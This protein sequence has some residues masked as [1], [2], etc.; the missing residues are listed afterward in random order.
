MNSFNAYCKVSISPVRS[1]SKD[2]SEIVTQLLFGELITVHEVNEPWAKITTITDGYEGIIDFKHFQKLTDKE[3]KRWSDGLSILKVRECELDTPWGLLRICRGSFIP[4]DEV[5][6]KIG[7]DHFQLLSPTAANFTTPWDYA[8]DYLNTPYLWGGKSPFGIDCS[9]I[10]QIIYR[11]FNINLPRDADEQVLVGNDVEFDEIVS[12]DLA[13][14][15]NKTGKI[16][17]VGICN[18]N[19]EIIHAAGHVRKDKLTNNGIIHAESGF[20]THKLTCIKRVL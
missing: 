3:S 9:G 8:I 5:E 15:E 7:D 2:Q 18:G 19:G 14:F 17:H 20:L 12:G 13:Y 11:I 10:T 6:F 16:T 4:N 1:E